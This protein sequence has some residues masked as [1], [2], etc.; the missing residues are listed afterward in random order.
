M[1]NAEHIKP[2]GS[3]LTVL[4]RAAKARLAIEVGTFT[5]YFSICIA[6]G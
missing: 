5:G 2:E 1:L 3:L 4:A 6:R